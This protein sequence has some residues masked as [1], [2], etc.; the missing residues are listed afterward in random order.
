M[1]SDTEKSPAL[2]DTN[3]LLYAYAEN[4]PKRRKAAELLEACVNGKE[5]HFLSLQNIGEFCSV[6]IHKYGLEVREV[7][8]TVEELLHTS[9]LVKVQYSGETLQ[10]ALTVMKQSHISFWDAVLVATM[11]EN[12]I[13][14]IYTEDAAFGKIEG[15]KALNP[16]Q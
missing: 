6:A 15:I 3:I 8:E 14:T 13:E 2:I 12:V 1:K 10:R 4:S 5:K 11:K 16:F 7:I 9:N